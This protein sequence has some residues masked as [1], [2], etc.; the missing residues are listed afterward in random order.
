MTKIFFILYYSLLSYI[1]LLW[2]PFFVNEN[3]SFISE[4]RGF[5]KILK[6]YKES[7][8]LY[9]AIFIFTTP[10]LGWSV[11]FHNRLLRVFIAFLILFIF[12]MR[13][14][15]GIVLHGTHSWIVSC[16]WMCFISEKENISSK[17]NLTVIRLIQATILSHYFFAGLWK[18]L[19]LF[20]VSSWE[21][22]HSHL[23]DQIAYSLLTV[24]NGPNLSLVQ[25]L[26]DL[27]VLLIGFLLV[28]VFQFSS[29]LPVLLNRGFIFYGVAIVGFH[30]ITGITLGV[31]FSNTIL[32]VLFFLII[33][34]FLLK[35]ERESH[36][37]E[38]SC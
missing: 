35:Q 16:I 24:S 23:L 20:K 11:L 4:F 27:P 13:S 21:M 30:I 15:F 33:T 22:Y 2:G 10:F 3:T 32:A 5:A 12:F 17:H 14:S 37:R 7:D 28:V 26:S 38:L 8:L 6:P 1:I 18:S 25:R 19:K 31:W 29:L 9:P 34:E 36:S